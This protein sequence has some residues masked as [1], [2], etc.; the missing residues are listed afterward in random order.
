MKWYQEVGNGGNDSYED[1]GTDHEDGQST[2]YEAGER[3]TA[4]VKVH[5]ICHVL[6]I[7]Y[8]K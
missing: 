2:N 3:E 5:E 4:M 7:N 6:C 8:T 1:R